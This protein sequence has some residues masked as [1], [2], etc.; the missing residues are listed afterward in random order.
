MLPDDGVQLVA[1][2]LGDVAVDGSRMDE[3]CCRSEAIVVV[4]EMTRMLIALR[5]LGHKPAK[6]LEHGAANRCSTPRCMLAARSPGG[7]RADVSL[8]HTRGAP[9]ALSS[10]AR[11]FLCAGSPRAVRDY[12][13]RRRCRDRVSALPVAFRGHA[14]GR[15]AAYT[16]SRGC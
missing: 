7:A 12:S 6:A 1:L 9:A 11:S 13:S 2:G 15:R 3:Q 8:E 14:A 16:S 10:T 4:A 5:Y